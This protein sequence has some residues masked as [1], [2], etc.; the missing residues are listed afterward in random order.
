MAQN[1][2]LFKETNVASEDS[3]PNFEGSLEISFVLLEN[4]SHVP[5]WKH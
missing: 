1:Y 2:I 3:K 5:M 4:I